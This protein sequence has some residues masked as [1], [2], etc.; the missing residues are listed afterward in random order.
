MTMKRLDR[1]RPY[2]ETI[3]RS[4]F[5]G[6]AFRISHE[7][8]LATIQGDL[9]TRY[10]DCSHLAWAYRLDPGHERASD[11]GEPQGTAGLP[12]LYIIQKHALVETGVA[13]V[14][15]F[16]GIK[17]GR[18]GLIRAYERTALGALGESRFEVAIAALRITLRLSYPDY[19][20][21]APR[22]DRLD[23]GH[24][25]VF[26]AIVECTLHCPAPQWPD[27]ASRLASV[28]GML[29]GKPDPE[30]IWRPE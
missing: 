28:T 19:A 17:L 4:R 27:L 14:R 2:L 10:P 15:Y 8:D 21:L 18:G 29:P 26:G 24:Q 3:E 25:D 23:I 1:S 5:I 7:R 20:V 12:I 16:G 6:Q 22:W 11:D 9:Q 13:V 30:T